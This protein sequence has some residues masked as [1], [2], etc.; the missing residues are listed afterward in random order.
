M[1]VYMY[2]NIKDILVWYKLNKILDGRFAIEECITC[3]TCSRVDLKYEIIVN[4]K[5]IILST[6]VL[7]VY[8]KYISVLA[9]YINTYLD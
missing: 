2:I 3:F 1:Y 5:V 6:Y 9:Y 4:I 7:L 8:T